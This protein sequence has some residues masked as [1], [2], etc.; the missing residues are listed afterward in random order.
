MTLFEAIKA[1]GIPFDNHESDLYLP[2]TP[3]A[4]AVL[5]QFPREQSIATRFTNKRPPNAGEQWIDVPFAYEPFWE[6]KLKQHGS[7]PA[8]KVTHGPPGRDGDRLC[9]LVVNPE[10]KLLAVLDS[11]SEAHFYIQNRGHAHGAVYFKASC[12]Y[13]AAPALLEALEYVEK[14]IPVAR[15]Y[16]PKSIRN[17]DSFQLEN[18]CATIGKAIHKAGGAK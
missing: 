4:R 5:A 9:W 15:K 11:Q 13:A 1:I 8:P 17:S 3:E 12:D 6:E 14:L 2:D 16:F 10:G 7:A 18:A